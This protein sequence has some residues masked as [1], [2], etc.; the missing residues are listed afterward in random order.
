MSFTENTKRIF[1]VARKPSWKEFWNLAKI[2]GLGIAIVGLLGFI[3]MLI[4]YL[5]YSPIW[6]IK[7]DFYIKG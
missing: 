3:I 7:N 4:M 5:L 1:L 2:V 6:G